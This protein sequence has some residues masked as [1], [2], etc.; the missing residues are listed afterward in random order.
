MVLQQSIRCMIEVKDQEDPINIEPLA[1]LRNQLMRRPSGVIGSIFSFGGFTAPATTLAHFMSPHG[2]L[3][4]QGEEIDA[5]L[6]RRDF[7]A[8]LGKKHQ[9]L[10]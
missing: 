4:W 5:V 2:I 1:K 10:I 8:A 6:R 3:L 9:L 7:T